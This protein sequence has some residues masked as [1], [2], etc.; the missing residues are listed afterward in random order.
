[1]SRVMYSQIQ[2]DV[3]YYVCLTCFHLMLLLNFCLLGVPEHERPIKRGM[4][5]LLQRED[6]GI[7]SSVI[8]SVASV[9]CLIQASKMK[10]V[11]T[12]Y[13]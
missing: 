6:M 7:C 11:K 13:L 3:T 8:Q 9:S 2:Y 5:R 12:K 10:K 1:M 4:Y